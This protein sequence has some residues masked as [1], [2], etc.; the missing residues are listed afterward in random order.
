MT[1][2]RP[3]S[4]LL[5]NQDKIDDLSKV[6]CPP[7][8]IIS[9]QD[10]DRYHAKHPFNLIRLILGKELA[11]DNQKENKYIRA[12]HL[13]NT[14]I[15]EKILKND[16]KESLYFYLQ[17]YTIRGEK[18]KRLGF[19][20]L[21]RLEDKEEST[22]FAH[23]NTH[24]APKED[25]LQLLKKVRAN[26]SPIFTLFS[27]EK[28][29][30]NR[31][32]DEHLKNAQELISLT[33]QDKVSHKLWRF[34]DEEFINKLKKYIENRHIFIAD[35]HHR[36]EVAQLY[37]NQ[38]CKKRKDFDKEA[39]YNYILTYF[40][41]INSK[42]ITILPIHRV[43]KKLPRSILDLSRLFDIEKIKTK[44]DL[45]LFM[46]KAGLA[47][48]AFGLY[49]DG[50]FFLL[51]LKNE[52]SIGNLIKGGSGDYKRLDVVVLHKLI[53]ED[54]LG[55]K[56]EDVLFVKDEV[57]ALDLIGQNLAEAVFF[58]NPTKIEQLRSIA[59]NNERMPPK[60]TFFYPKLLSGLVIHKFG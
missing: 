38:I 47:E 14:W 9:S 13:F 40:T 30:I 41:D 2:I 28:K 39:G 58:L 53:L 22:V 5:Y 55:I 27:D 48:H 44:E 43:I 29:Y 50:R 54:I 56:D 1:K 46:A 37:L 52:R 3:F 21:M 10:Q 59:L 17:E 19:I 7:Y 24:L 15:K 25:R 45:F 36:W 42:E 4:A 60:S 26:L 49:H 51:R 11:S 23:E 20:S 16:E 18:K 33:D 31:I 12:A 8:D 6:V 35:G 32:Y 34:I 57:Q